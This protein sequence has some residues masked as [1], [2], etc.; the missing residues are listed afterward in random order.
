MNLIAL[1]ITGPRTRAQYLDERRRPP[2]APGEH[3]LFVSDEEDLANAYL[4]ALE[5][6]QVGHGRFD[7]VFI[8][9]DE[10]EQ[11][12]NLSKAR[13][14]LE[15]G[16]A[17][18]ALS[19]LKHRVTDLVTGTVVESPMT[20][21]WLA[22]LALVPL[23]AGGADRAGHRSGPVA[24]ERKVGELAELRLRSGDPVRRLGERHRDPDDQFRGHVPERLPRHPDRPHDGHRQHPR[25]R[26]GQRPGRSRTRPARGD[27]EPT[28]CRRRLAG[29]GSTSTSSRPRTRPGPS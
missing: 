28:A 23:L 14:L 27:R 8:A 9:G 6:V 13:R 26:D 7:A 1:R 10:R 29:C 2:P 22:V 18:A 5:A 25:E 20:R 11:E 15:L 17:L 21:R 19:S 16:A 24:V 12:H 3:R 4:A